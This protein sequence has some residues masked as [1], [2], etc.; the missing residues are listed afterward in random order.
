MG[1]QEFKVS[2]SLYRKNLQK[3][4]YN[5]FIL[6]LNCNDFFRKIYLKFEKPVSVLIENYKHQLK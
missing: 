5:D 2:Y 3:K 6:A 4:S 1:K